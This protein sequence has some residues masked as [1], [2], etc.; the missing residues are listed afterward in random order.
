MDRLISCR[1]FPPFPATV[2]DAR[3]R[4]FSRRGPLQGAVRVIDRIPANDFPPFPA[5]VSADAQQERGVALGYATP[6]L[7]R[8]DRQREVKD[9]PALAP[10][11]PGNA[12]REAP[13]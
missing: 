10:H 8:S 2:S 5:N 3:R 13:P 6:P 12:P 7:S 11:R 4:I 1:D 9:G